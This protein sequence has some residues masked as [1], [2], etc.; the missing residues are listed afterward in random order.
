MTTHTRTVRIASARG[1]HARPAK[2][3]VETAK[4]SSAS[5]TVTKDGGKAANGASILAVIAL[6][7]NAGDEITVTVDGENAEET[8]DA[9]VTILE[10]D[11]DAED[12]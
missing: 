1:L 5:V 9:L 11:H 10:T 12:A 8:L 3:F 6:G 2:L 7:L 4:A